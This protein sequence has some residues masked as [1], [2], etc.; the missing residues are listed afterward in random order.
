M[1]AGRI[2]ARAITVALLYAGVSFH[3][4]LERPLEAQRVLSATLTVSAQSIARSVPLEVAS[5]EPILVRV[6]SPVA[7]GLAVSVFVHASGGELVCRDDP[8][9][10]SDA[11]RCQPPAAGSYYV[12]LGTAHK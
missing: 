8:E 4:V 2:T 1:T 10:T 7:P 3:T 6:Q 9:S 5:N 12:L 11:F